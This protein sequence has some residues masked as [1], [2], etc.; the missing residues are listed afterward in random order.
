[1]ASGGLNLDSIQPRY[2]FVGFKFDFF[3]YVDFPLQIL[4]I[5]MIAGE[6]RG[7]IFI[8]ICCFHLFTT[9]GYLPN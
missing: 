5:Q 9:T 3:F 7:T 4:T 6:W 1:M 8:P 2:F